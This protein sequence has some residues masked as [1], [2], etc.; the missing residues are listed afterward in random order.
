MSLAL[1]A[2]GCPYINIHRVFTCYARS[3]GLKYFVS[4]YVSFVSKI[5]L[6]IMITFIKYLHSAIKVVLVIKFWFFYV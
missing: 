6:Q 2:T 4:F 5:S 3:K 1:Q